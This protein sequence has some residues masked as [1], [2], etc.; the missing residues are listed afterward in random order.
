MMTEMTIMAKLSFLRCLGSNNIWPIV[1]YNKE[2]HT[3]RE[4]EKR[5]KTR[6]NIRSLPVLIASLVVCLFL[7]RG[8]YGIF[9]KSRQAN[10]ER[11]ALAAKLED[12][13]TRETELEGDL[14]KLATPAGVEEE[15][16]S[17][18]NV[19]KAG[20]NVAIIVEPSNAE[21]TTTKEKSPWYSRL[22][23]AIIFWK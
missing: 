14:T 10:A 23:D 8:A 13:K 18:F 11:D 19:A 9:K 21:S 3:M 20:E 15:I 6:R 16:K 5:R 7:V 4:L 1:A 2:K 22:L 12:L 17:K